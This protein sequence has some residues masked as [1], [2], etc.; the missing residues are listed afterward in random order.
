MKDV[1]KNSSWK[2]ELHSEEGDDSTIPYWW[3]QQ[4]LLIKKMR[5]GVGWE[6]ILAVAENVGAIYEDKP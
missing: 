6:A 4:D 3:Q 5:C 2:T 1:S